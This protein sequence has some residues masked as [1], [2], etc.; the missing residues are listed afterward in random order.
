M[1]QP[2]CSTRHARS[3][4]V[5]KMSHPRGSLTSKLPYANFANWAVFWIVAQSPPVTK[6]ARRK[7]PYCFCHIQPKVLAR[8]RKN[9]MRRFHHAQMMNIIFQ[10][11]KTIGKST[12]VLEMTANR[13]DGAMRDVLVGYLSPLPHSGMMNEKALLSGLSAHP[14]SCFTV[15]V[16]LD[17]FHISSRFT[18]LFTQFSHHS[19]RDAAL[20]LFAS[21]WTQ[22]ICYALSAGAMWSRGSWLGGSLVSAWYVCCF[23]HLLV[24]PGDV[25]V[26]SSFCFFCHTK[27][28][29]YNVITSC[30]ISSWTG[31]CHACFGLVRCCCFLCLVC[32]VFCLFFVCLVFALFCFLVAFL[33]RPTGLYTSPL[34]VHSW[35]HSISSRPFLHQLT[36]RPNL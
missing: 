2:S 35:R 17:L 15:R 25:L 33:W 28:R 6:L 27:L 16:T 31:T 1:L 32:V 34:P 5:S 24:W 29:W 19:R 11:M 14:E 10:L 22:V 12:S 30:V 18:F 7:K 4:K 20:P 21:K 26:G 36:M 13:N 9:S 3:F 8:H 23:A